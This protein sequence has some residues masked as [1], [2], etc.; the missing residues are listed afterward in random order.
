MTTSIGSV[1]PVG[2]CG[3]TMRATTG[4]NCLASSSPAG[5]E[6]SLIDALGAATE[7]Y[8]ATYDFP[9]ATGPFKEG[10]FIETERT[11]QLFRVAGPTSDDE[12]PGY[13]LQ[14]LASNGTW[15]DTS[16]VILLEDG[17]L[18]NGYRS[19]GN[20]RLPQFVTEEDRD[21]PVVDK[22]LTLSNQARWLDATHKDS[23]EARALADN[24]IVQALR[25][26]EGAESVRRSGAHY[27]PSH[28]H[29]ANGM[30]RAW[31]QAESYGVSE[32]E[33]EPIS[34]AEAR[35]M[36]PEGSE[37]TAVY[38][39]IPPLAP[40]GH[41]P[42]P[43]KRRVLKQTDSEM[44]TLDAETNQQPHLR[45]NKQQAYLSNGHVVIADDLGKPYVAYILD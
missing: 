8:V 12:R 32:T 30:N 29:R 24:A 10:Q 45:W 37:F 13:R 34:K 41:L 20:V 38:L 33:M 5:G 4:C 16:G 28:V 36:M 18:H 44:V 14:F 27:T 1:H 7:P 11:G 22:I 26:P 43:A 15:T 3:G 35:R 19:E 23:R 40:A 39:Q 17:T 25:T 21:D 2:S 9:V 6:Q 42:P 31:E